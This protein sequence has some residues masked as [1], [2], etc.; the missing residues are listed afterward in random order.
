MEPT[1]LQ[2]T[3]RAIKIWADKIMPQ[4]TPADAIKKLSMEEVPELW[5]S[6][7]ETGE[8]DEGEIAD[9]LILAL[10][11]CAM[12]GIDPMEAIHQKMAINVCRKWKL[13]YGVLQ[14]EDE[15]L[16]NELAELEADKK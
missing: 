4:R 12:S 6:L 8:V 5:R 1:Q 9:V 10:D 2:I 7:K 15:S 14:H 16:A 11:V 13:E 3:T